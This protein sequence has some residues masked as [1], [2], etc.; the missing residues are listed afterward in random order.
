MS[1]HLIRGCS[2]DAETGGLVL[3][4]LTPAADVRLNGMVLNHALLIPPE[5]P[6]IGLIEQVEATLQNVL[7][8]ALQQFSDALVM[9]PPVDEDGPG[10]FDNP[11]E[12]DA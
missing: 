8:A 1:D 9:D 5:D 6:F 7:V 12:R 2:L 4:Y 10:P 11:L 3:E